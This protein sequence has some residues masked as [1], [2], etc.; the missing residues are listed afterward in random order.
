MIVIE[1]SDFKLTQVA[2]SSN[3]W[4][5]ELLYTVKPKGK[6]S[7]EEFKVAGYGMTMETC[8][9]R[10]INHRIA[11]KHPEAIDMKTYFAEYK[12]ALKEV[13]ELCQGVQKI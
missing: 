10:I 7:R 11:K 13:S 6:E 1:E 9:K 5:L 2:D 4:D 8:I 12:Q 3:F